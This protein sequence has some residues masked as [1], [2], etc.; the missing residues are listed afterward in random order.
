[1]KGAYILITLLA[2]SNLQAQWLET[3]AGPTPRINNGLV[4]DSSGAVYASDLFGSGFNGNS[5][6]LIQTNGN[7][8]LVVS[9]LSQ[10]AGLC[11]GPQRSLYIAEFSANRIRV[12]DSSGIL[13]PF[14][15]GMSQPADLV[16]N[17]QGQ[18]FVSNYGN[19]TISKIESDTTVSTFCS[20][21]NKPVGLCIDENDKLYVAN[22][23]DGIIYKIPASGQKD[24]LTTIPNTPLGFM[25]YA[26][27]Q[28]YVTATD[29]N[30]VY[31]IDIN[32]RSYSVL[33]GT[34]I[35]GNT[36]GA[37]DSAQFTKPD[38]IAISPNGDTLYVSENNSNLL[39]RIILSYGIGSWENR[40][41]QELPFYPNP[42]KNQVFLDL[43]KFEGHQF[44][45]E[46]ISSDGKTMALLYQ[47]SKQGKLQIP[48]PKIASGTYYL[49]IES[50][51]SE[52]SFPLR[53][54]P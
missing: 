18:L 36:N 8:S 10:P 43:K 19:G 46:L 26:N 7:S 40:I 33:I 14:V 47:G 24:S 4:V 39:R 32:S 11:L 22:L 49:H 2:F 31:Q 51:Q 25:T 44:R 34:G 5:I 1:M 20:G 45:I 54:C 12:L 35:S 15:N 3:V 48:L 42:A 13:H 41:N 52:S 38:G 23:Q 21:L 50:D 27:G 29:A 53:I 6:F 37:K 17:S 9:G 16:F 30:Q 28:L